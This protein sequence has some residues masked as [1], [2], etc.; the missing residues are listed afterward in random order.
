M[1]ARK[2][3]RRLPR[4]K[5]AISPAISTAI[6]TSAII[7]MLLVTIVFVNNYLNGQIAQ[8]EFNSMEQYM[9]TLGLQV[10]DVAWIPGRTQTLTY[11]SKYG[12]ITFRSPALTY[13]FYFNGLLVA[14]F[15]V[16]VVMF[17]IPVSSYSV[18]N[19]YF[20]ELF[21]SSNGFLQNG[22]GAP[23]GRVFV[24]EEMPMQD[25]SYI[26][27]VVAPIVRQLNAVING[28]N[29]AEFYLPVLNQGP[30]P[31]LTQSVTLTGVNVQQ[32]I[33]N[34]VNNVTITVTFPNA[35]GM[36]LSSGFFNFAA[37][38]QTVIL[39]SNSVVEIYGGIVT[40]SLGVS[41]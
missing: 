8:N 11:A 31:Q 22:T 18:G 27:V 17:N 9:Q 38:S 5:R 37:T 3:L 30:S 35:V 40:V 16:G 23:V 24:T 2:P 6:L 34:N 4:N 19:N 41:A 7:V 12:G 36:G 29:Y 26:R 14:N 25:G 33:Y 20:D 28:V 10:D 39:G 1:A 32:E 15:S 21:P 13:D